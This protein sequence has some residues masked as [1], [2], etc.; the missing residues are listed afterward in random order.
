[1]EI[2]TKKIKLFRLIND[3]D[4][5]TEYLEDGDFYKFISPMRLIIDADLEKQS[6]S[7]YMYNWLPQGVSKDNVAL[8]NK[9][10]VICVSELEEDI[11]EHY[12]AVVFDINDSPKTKIIEKGSKKIE[13]LDDERKVI[14]FKNNKDIN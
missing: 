1:M 13:H 3:C 10:Y 4:V 12:A 14:S 6:Q 5:I 9:S 11:I 2:D 8:I 7:I